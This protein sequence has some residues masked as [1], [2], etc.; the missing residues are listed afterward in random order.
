[1]KQTILILL[2]YS[3]C[4]LSNLTHSVESP[5]LWFAV[6][7]QQ[8]LKHLLGTSLS[9]QSTN[10]PRAA[11]KTLRFPSHQWTLPFNCPPHFMQ[12]TR[13]K[14]ELTWQTCLEV[15]CSQCSQAECPFSRT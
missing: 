3:K 12:S 14:K 1:M 10:I 6:G 11:P 8:N 7:F 15:Q 5:V 13:V 9:A 4:F 2:C